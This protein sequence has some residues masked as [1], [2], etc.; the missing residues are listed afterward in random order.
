MKKFYKSPLI[1][2]LQI[3]ELDII[4]GSTGT[5]AVFV[6]GDVRDLNWEE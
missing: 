1:T 2:V 4:T 3:K 5:P 6:E